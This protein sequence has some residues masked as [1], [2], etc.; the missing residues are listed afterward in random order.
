MTAMILQA[1]R[2]DVIGV[3]AEGDGWADVTAAAVGEIG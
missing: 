3:W 2:Q 1:R